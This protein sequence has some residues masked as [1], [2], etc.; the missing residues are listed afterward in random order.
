LNQSVR[1]Q[2]RVHYLIGLGGRLSYGLQ[3]RYLLGVPKKDRDQII[4]DFFKGILPPS[5]SQYPELVLDVTNRELVNYQW[6]SL[7]PQVSLISPTYKTYIPTVYNRLN[8]SLADIYEEGRY[9]GN[10]RFMKGVF[11]YYINRPTD[12]GRWGYFTPE[13]VY[14]KA[15]YFDHN[16]LRGAWKRYYYTLNHNKDWKKISL[17]TGY[18]NTFEEDGISPFEFDTFNIS[19]KE[20]TNYTLFYQLFDNLRVSYHQDFS[21]TDNEV[22]NTDYGADFKLCCWNIAIYWYDTQG[23][24]A[25]NISLD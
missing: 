4:D 23:K 20:E 7:R 8:V 25:F 2:L 24:F 3:T 6:L 1:G 13:V 5:N 11:N 12:L 22:R 9:F 14:M 15:G 21:I 18:K 19:T 17:R 10:K 16:N